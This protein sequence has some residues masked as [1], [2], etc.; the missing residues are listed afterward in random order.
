MGDNE[1]LR[2][3]Y[4]IFEQL[5]GVVTAEGGAFEGAVGHTLQRH[6]AHGCV[7]RT[8]RDAAKK[9]NSTLD[10]WL[11]TQTSQP[12]PHQNHTFLTTSNMRFAAKTF[13]QVSLDVERAS[14]AHEKASNFGHVCSVSSAS[15]SRLI[16][17]YVHLLWYES[18][19]C[20][21]IHPPTAGSGVGVGRRAHAARRARGRRLPPEVCRRGPKRGAGRVR[22]GRAPP[23]RGAR[24]AAG[25][26]ARVGV[27]GAG[28]R[29]ARRDR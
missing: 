2:R 13:G 1:C 29:G 22:R 17:T 20:A 4:A 24:R 27:L 3:L 21:N 5:V 10:F 25:A 8:P 7:C 9:S 18:S 12:P 28:R 15:Q 14:L 23:Q 16:T 6:C 11:H 26:G 19:R